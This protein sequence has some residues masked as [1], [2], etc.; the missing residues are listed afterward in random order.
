MDLPYKETQPTHFG[1]NSE[2][3]Y[4]IAQT[5]VF[6]LQRFALEVDGL[7]CRIYNIGEFGSFEED[8]CSCFNQQHNFLV[9]NG[10]EL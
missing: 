8:A 1:W 7:R 2:N 5:T 6:F 9:S 10:L 4:T 3:S